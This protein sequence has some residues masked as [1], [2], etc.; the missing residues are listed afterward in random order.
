M[1]IKSKRLGVGDY[2]DRTWSRKCASEGCEFVNRKS[3][4]QKDAFV[5]I[6]IDGSVG[7]S[8]NENGG[9]REERSIT[10]MV[11]EMT[12]HHLMRMEVK[13]KSIPLAKMLR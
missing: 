8:L 9:D 7:A 1:L 2:E 4:V 11:R 3:G 5:Q 10:K 6:S 13:E 12:E